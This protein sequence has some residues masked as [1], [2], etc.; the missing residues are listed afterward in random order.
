V[1]SAVCQMSH[2]KALGPDGLLAGF[3]KENWEIIGEDVC[4]AILQTLATGF[5][6]EDLNFT[7]IALIPKTLQPSCVLEFW[8][9]SL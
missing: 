7:Y 2:L 3:F 5:I 4:Q 9:I 1:S 8:P 6:N